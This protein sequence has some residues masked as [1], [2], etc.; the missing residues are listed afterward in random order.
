MLCSGRTR[1]SKEDAQLAAACLR[2]SQPRRSELPAHLAGRGLRCAAL[3]AAGAGPP[4]PELFEEA[5]AAAA[6]EAAEISQASACLGLHAGPDCILWA[7]GV[8]DDFG[9]ERPCAG[10]AVAGTEP[11]AG[12]DQCPWSLQTCRRLPADLLSP[13]SGG[14]RP[15]P[16]GG[17]CGMGNA[18]LILR[19]GFCVKGNP[20]DQIG[21][22][23]L[24]PDEDDPASGERLVVLAHRG[25]STEHW[26]AAQPV[27]Q[28]SG[29][30]PAGLLGL[31]E[32]LRV[33]LCRGSPAEAPS[34]SEVPVLAAHELD[35]VCLH[36]IEEL[37][38]GLL[39][40]QVDF[41][42]PFR[43]PLSA[44]QEGHWLILE[45]HRAAVA[46][47]LAQAREMPAAK[48]RRLSP[49]F[50]SLL[51]R[52]RRGAV[53]R[54]CHRRGAGAARL[55]ESPRAAPPGGRLARLAAAARRRRVDGRA[56]AGALRGAPRARAGEALIAGEL[57]RSETSSSR[58]AERAARPPCR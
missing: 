47:L 21:P 18:E 5:R 2:A 45:E 6:A 51:L 58:A 19:H 23:H 44:W 15:G 10:E 34:L 13:S 14:R 52:R 56:P 37:L 39:P 33:L 22:L 53:R 32:C 1:A 26:L 17:P 20:H 46:D 12:G 29:A 8:L 11:C 30:P 43:E 49:H 40:E 28:A 31:L 4:L 38:S 55:Q 9:S 27:G 48:R 35:V 16:A 42:G 57:A 41:R 54:R 24:D 36:A 3:P 50:F 7:L 25:I